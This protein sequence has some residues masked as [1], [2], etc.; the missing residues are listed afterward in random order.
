[1][2]TVCATKPTQIVAMYKKFFSIRLLKNM[3][4]KAAQR[5]NTRSTG[6]SVSLLF[7]STAAKVG[8]VARC[9]S[10]ILNQPSVCALSLPRCSLKN[11]N[12]KVGIF[13]N[14]LIIDAN[15]CFPLTIK[16]MA[17]NFGDFFP[18]PAWIDIVSM[19]IQCFF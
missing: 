16:N 19:I 11:T 18:L 14:R 6:G 8:T 3:V 1:M 10:M 5:N 17:S 7:N 13:F 2:I 12:T 9:M 15:I 4:I